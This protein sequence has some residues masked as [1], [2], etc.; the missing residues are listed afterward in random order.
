MADVPD[1]LQEI[2]LTCLEPQA[3]NRYASAALLAF[4]LMHPDQVKV[5][6]RGHAL[7][8]AGFGGKDRCRTTPQDRGFDFDGFCGGRHRVGRHAQRGLAVLELEAL[9]VRRCDGGWLDLLAGDVDEAQRDD[10][11]GPERRW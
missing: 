6:A 4:D 8:G 2:I 7:R 11:V 9:I 10:A 3:E 5:G 1:W